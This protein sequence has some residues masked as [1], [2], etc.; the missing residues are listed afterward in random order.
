VN[1]LDISLR[2]SMFALNKASEPVDCV[3]TSPL[4]VKVRAHKT[5]LYIE[6][7]AVW[8]PG[9]AFVSPVV[10]QMHEGVLHYK[11]V[12]IEA[13]TSGGDEIYFVIWAH[14]WPEPVDE[15][16]RLCGAK[17]SALLHR[18]TCPNY[19]DPETL[20]M[21]GCATR[22]YAGDTWV[23]VQQADLVKLR[24]FLDSGERVVVIS[25]DEPVFYPRFS[26]EIRSISF[27]AVE[28]ALRSFLD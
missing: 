8:Q 23:G 2:L 13:I 11:D 24:E 22:G 20:A 21:V 26:Q 5:W 7:E 4:G 12:K 19:A 27:A 16:C 18:T 1:P 28:H 15:L 6:D 3:F 17:P 10:A 9:G 25:D 14:K